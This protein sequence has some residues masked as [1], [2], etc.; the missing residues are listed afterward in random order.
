MCRA[1]CVAVDDVRNWGTAVKD[2]KHIWLGPA[3]KPTKYVRADIA[4]DLVAAL[5]CIAGMIDDCAGVPRNP[6]SLP[7]MI[8][9]CAR[10]ALAK[11][12]GET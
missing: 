10:A 5:E 2:Q 1:L 6:D 12:R 4:D 7:M 11:A 9:E 3:A 8:S